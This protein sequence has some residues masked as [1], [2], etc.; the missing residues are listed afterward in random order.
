VEGDYFKDSTLATPA[1]AA[2][3]DLA[4]STIFFSQLR[5]GNRIHGF[6]LPFLMPA[7]WN[8]KIS[9]LYNQS[10]DNIKQKNPHLST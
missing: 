4:F 9:S 6:V 5:A 7:R 2:P 8:A 1:M 3:N 10:A